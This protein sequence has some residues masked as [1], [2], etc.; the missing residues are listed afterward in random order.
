MPCLAYAATLAIFSSL[1]KNGKIVRPTFIFNKFK[2][3]FLSE[4]SLKDMQLNFMLCF[5]NV[6]VFHLILSQ[7]SGINKATQI[8]Y[9]RLD[10]GGIERLSNRH[11]S[12]RTNV[13]S[14]VS[15]R[16]SNQS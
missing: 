15:H 13:V 4:D 16:Y 1:E 8:R 7:Q 10:M 11:P 3:F 9:H 12:Y 2:L 5:F 14:V 6:S